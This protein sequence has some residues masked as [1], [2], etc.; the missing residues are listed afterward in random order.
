MD[1][2][3]PEEVVGAILKNHYEKTIDSN[4]YHKIQNV[5]HS[6]SDR[7]K[8]TVENE[9]RT[10]LFIARGK[11]RDMTK[12]SLI[13][14]IVEKAGISAHL[15]NEVDIFDN[16]S[17]VTVPFVEAEII[18][19]KFRKKKNGGRPLIQEAAQS[20]KPKSKGKRRRN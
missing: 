17:F 5:R 3:S 9:G 4:N 16:F 7:H 18:L 2:K 19:D 1:D 20:K 13:S 8:N 14:F 15:I 11:S 10:R 12:K 6:K